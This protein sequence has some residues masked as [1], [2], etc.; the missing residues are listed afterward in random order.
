MTEGDSL[1]EAACAA[2]EKAHAPYSE[3]KVG[4]AV[5][6]ADGSIFSGANVENASY[7]LSLCAERSAVAWMVSAGQCEI[8][9]VAIWTDTPEPTPPCGGC[10][11]VLAE[12][13]P[14]PA[15]LQIT[16]AC[17]TGVNYSTLATLLPTGFSQLD[18]K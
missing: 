6:A 9:A 5:R 10:R 2:A 13:A 8:E 1:V 4:A 11:Q 15:T 12:F 3:F 17:P 7:P 18:P 16:M 14:D